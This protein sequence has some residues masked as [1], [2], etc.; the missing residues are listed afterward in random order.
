[1]HDLNL[2]ENQSKRPQAPGLDEEGGD[3][4]V[5]RAVCHVHL[6]KRIYLINVVLC[7]GAYCS[8]AFRQR[9]AMNQLLWRA[10][11]LKIV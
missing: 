10:V 7:T 8:Q 1:M 11:F 5:Y 3:G 9:P 2:R 6:L 4:L